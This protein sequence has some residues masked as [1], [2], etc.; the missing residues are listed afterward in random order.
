[1]TPRFTRS[2]LCL[3][4]LALSGCGDNSADRAAPTATPA[5]NPA[6]ASAGGS[7]S[8]PSGGGGTAPIATT[9]MGTGA[10][11]ATGGA[12][13]ALASAGQSGS[14]SAEAPSVEN[15]WGFAMRLPQTR[16]LDC[17]LKMVEDM[18]AQQVSD[19]DQICTF[20]YDGVTGH[21]YLE[22]TAVDCEYYYALVGLFSTRAWL[23]IDGEVIPL[24]DARYSLGGDHFTDSLSF[25]YADKHY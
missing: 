8:T 4:A 19:A 6:A 7:A 1:M 5:D 18:P 11:P 23:S 25:T 9:A 2:M 13:G 21:V 20:S 24:E 15:P 12:S 17:G 22:A 16:L 10:E 3:A 14:P